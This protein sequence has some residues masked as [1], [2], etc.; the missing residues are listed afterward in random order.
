MPVEVPSMPVIVVPLELVS[1]A[2]STVTPATGRAGQRVV[3]P[4]RVVMMTLRVSGKPAGFPPRKYGCRGPR[5]SD[6][7]GSVALVS[8]VTPIC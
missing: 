1:G 3:T 2:S 6:A 7:P 4:P 5:R 8:G